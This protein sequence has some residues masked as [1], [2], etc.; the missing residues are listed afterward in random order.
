MILDFI[1]LF[2][3][4]SLH[5]QELNVVVALHKFLASIECT[6]SSLFASI[7]S[8]LPPFRESCF[9]TS[10]CSKKWRKPSLKKEKKNSILSGIQVVEES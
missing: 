8:S 6:F 9:S 3:E 10:F 5:L 2:I 4:P 1:I 7:S